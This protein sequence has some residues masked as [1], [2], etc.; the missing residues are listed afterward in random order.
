MV[1]SVRICYSAVCWP[2]PNWYVARQDREAVGLDGEKFE[3]AR[4]YAGEIRDGLVTSLCDFDLEDEDAAFAYAE[5]RIRAASSRL[6]VSNRASEVADVLLGAAQTRDTDAALAVYADEFTYDDRRRLSGDPIEDRAALGAAVARIGEQFSI[7]E[8]RTLAVRGERLQ[9]AWSRW[10]DDSGN[11]TTHLH[12]LEL[13]DD[14]RIGYYGRFDEDDF[15]GAYR[16]LEHRYSAGEGAAFAEGVTAAADHI[17]A[18]NQ[19]DFDRV[20]GELT[21]P[22]L[23]IENRSRAVVPDR[24]FAE[25]RASFEALGAMVASSRAWF[26]TAYWLSPNWVI[27]RHQREAV[28]LDGERY[29]WTRVIVTEFRDGRLMSA[30]EFDLEDEEAAFA[31][32]KERVRAAD[33]QPHPQS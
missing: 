8:G 30:C 4:L 5:E 11:E 23:R 15:D 24:S 17:T 32:G 9:L 25:L 13:D 28:G 6:A 1:S 27:A 20:F 14:G 31:Y 21:S 2:S 3:W 26:S 16:E 29:E 10:S 18:T 33:A 7:F 22:D 12:L 19:G